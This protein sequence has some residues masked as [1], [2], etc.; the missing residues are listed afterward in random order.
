LFLSSPD[1]P[2]TYWNL[3][4]ER[5]ST[6]LDLIHRHRITIAFAGH[7]HRNSLAYDGDFEMVTSGPVGYRLG[8]DPSGVR[9]VDVGPD[10]ILHEYVPLS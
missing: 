4:A 9:I 5:R 7:W 8:D 3:P 1:E 10:R 6:L 2:D